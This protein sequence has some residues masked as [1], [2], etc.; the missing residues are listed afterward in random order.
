MLYYR[1]GGEHSGEGHSSST[2]C[3]TFFFFLL[4]E[5]IARFFFPNGTNPFGGRRRILR[6]CE[7]GN[8][9]PGAKR[10]SIFHVA[11]TRGRFSNYA[12]TAGA[13]DVITKCRKPF[14]RDYT[15]FGSCFA[16]NTVPLRFYTGADTRIEDVFKNE[17]DENRV[18]WPKI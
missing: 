15:I 18:P 17:R 13:N 14:L 12:H 5:G 7:R 3:F 16:G 6:Y 8:R 9:V 2:Q 4:T 1:A 11:L 10:F